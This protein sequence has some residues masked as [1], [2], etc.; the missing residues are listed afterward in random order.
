MNIAYASTISDRF[1]EEI[2][3]P[4]KDPIIL[5]PDINL[6]IYRPTIKPEEEVA[7]PEAY[8]MRDEYLVFA[9]PRWQ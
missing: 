4:I 5:K 1:L 3:T 6:P 9:Q 7:L 8:S 2:K